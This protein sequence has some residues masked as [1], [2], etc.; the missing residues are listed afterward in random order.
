MM[1]DTTP[2]DRFADL[3]EHSMFLT[4][5]LSTRAHKRYEQA[6]W[7]CWGRQ[8]AGDERTRGQLS[9]HYLDDA[10]AFAEFAALE[11][12]SYEREQRCM[13]NCI[14]DQYGRFVADLSS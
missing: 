11:A 10:F 14:V 7:Y 8:D 1:S 5:R 9:G 6:L 3:F 12:E 2:D 4:T 13:L